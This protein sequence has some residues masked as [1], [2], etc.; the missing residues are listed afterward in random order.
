MSDIEKK[1]FPSVKR[2]IESLIE[3]EGGTIPAGKML[4][5]GTLMLVFG[6]VFAT[7]AFAAH[8]SH[9]SHSSHS[10]HSSGSSGYHSSHVSHTS[11]TS[12]SSG[13]HSSSSHGSH[14]SH[15][16]SSSHSASKSISGSSKT[17]VPIS[18]S[19]VLGIEAPEATPSTAVPNAG[20]HTQ[21]PG[22]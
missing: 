12:H 14:S 10:S 21:V 15:S 9:R 5:I 2:S 18:P 11:H 22:K 8:S 17:A 20:L 4:A 13:Y 16:S 7:E 19:E 6:M 1:Q 3:D